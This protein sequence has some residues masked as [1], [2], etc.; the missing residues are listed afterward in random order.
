MTI[1]PLPPVT[2]THL[3]R[4]TLAAFVLTF[5]TSRIVVLLIMTRRMPDLY[6][7][8]GETHVH[9]LN[10]GI[11]L[12]VV[13]CG[14]L[15][16]APPGDRV[17]RWLA[18]SYGVGLGLTFDEFGMWLHLD[19]VY[20]Q[21]ASYDAVVTI[22]ALLGLLAYAPAVRGFKR[23]HWLVL[24]SIAATIAVGLYLLADELKLLGP[25]LQK[26]EAAAP[27]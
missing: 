22:A 11:S 25:L 2:F 16:F 4:R 23:I 24:V 7:Y 3:A 1:S 21:R 5:L 27:R 17:R 26:I 18:L 8:A 15:L 14:W 12:L 10:Y 20:W 19:A 9:H 6:F 13:T